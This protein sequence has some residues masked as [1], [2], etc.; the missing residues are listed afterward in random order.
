MDQGELIM[1]EHTTGKVLSLN[2]SK[3]KGTRKTPVPEGVAMLQKDFGVAGDAHAGDWHR[4]VSLLA[5]ESIDPAK[6]MGIEANWGDFG[7]NITTEGLDLKALPIGTVLKIGDTHVQISQ[8]GKACHTR[9]AIFYLAGDCIFP[10]EG[11]FAWVQQPGSI[12]V[13]DTIT[14]ESLGDGTCPRTPQEALEEVK[15]FHKALDNEAHMR[16][17]TLKDALVEMQEA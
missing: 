1:T 17:A 14:I 7:E 15:I 13:G 2:I 9:C 12:R 16:E 4:Q 6:E 11:I 8:I 5:Q 3:K 10:R